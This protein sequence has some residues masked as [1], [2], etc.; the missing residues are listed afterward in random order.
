MKTQTFRSSMKCA[1]NG[2]YLSLKSEKNIRRHIL[3]T[4]IV[5]LLGTVFQLSIKE[6]L[7]I[8]L[9][10]GFV[11]TT[12]MLNT[13]IEATVDIIT[14]STNMQAKKA[15]D[16]AAGATLFS[17]ITSLIIGCII[18]LPKLILLFKE[19]IR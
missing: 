3:A 14:T 4:L 5:F 13:A 8:I 7:W 9:C 12:E 18:F 2:I 11:I 1:L 17:A 10:C 19:Y 15:K 6:W 16:I